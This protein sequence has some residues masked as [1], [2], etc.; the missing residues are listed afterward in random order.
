MD[1]GYRLLIGPIPVDR[2]RGGVGLGGNRGMNSS[3]GLVNR[4]AD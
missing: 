2:L 4:D 3:M 1:L